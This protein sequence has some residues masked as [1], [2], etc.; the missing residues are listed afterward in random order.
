MREHRVH[1]TINNE[2]RAR[3]VIT[4]KQQP[5]TFSENEQFIKIKI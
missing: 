2:A 3:Y 4:T 1:Y 5:K